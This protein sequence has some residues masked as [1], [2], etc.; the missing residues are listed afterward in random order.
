MPRARGTHVTAG[1]LAEALGGR[2]SGGSWTACCPGH[3]DR[4]PSLSISEAEDG[5][6]LV[7]CHAGCAQ[8]V[9]VGALATMGL[10]PTTTVGEL[11]TAKG[12]PVELLLESG[13]V[14][15]EWKDSPVIRMD[16]R[17]AD[18]AVICTRYRGGAGR[19]D[20]PRFW[21]KKGDKQQL[22]GLWRLNTTAPVIIVEGE[23][24]ALALW[25]ADFNAIGVPGCKAW[26]NKNDE[27]FAPLLKD[28]PIVY[29]HLEPD[30][31][32]QIHFRKAFERSVLRD[33]V[34]FFSCAPA[35]KDPCELRQ[36][37]PQAFRAAIDKLLEGGTP[38]PPKAKK[39]APVS[40]TAQT[41]GYADGRFEVRNDG[42]F[43]VTDGEDS[44]DKWLCSTVHITAQ[45]CDDHNN[46]WGRRL[47][48]VDGR[49]RPHCWSMPMALLEGDEAEVRQMLAA[50]GLRIA[51][52]RKAREY[53][54]A[55]LK[56]WPVDKHVRCVNRLGW[57]GEDYV[58]PDGVLGEQEEV[59][60]QSDSVLEPAFSARGTV[61]DWR[62]NVAA[63]AAG[64]TRLMF[65]ACVAFAAPL[66]ELVGAESGGF[67]LKG[68]SS[69]G[70]T[71]ALWLGAGIYGPPK[72]YVRSWR[73]TS[74]ALEST[75]ALHNDGL[76]VLDEVGQC[77]PRDIGQVVYMV[78]NEQGKARAY[79]TG[80]G[81]RVMSWRLL[82]L[83]SGEA[84]LDTQLST[85]KRRSSAGMEVRL[86]E[87]A[88]DAGKKQGVVEELHGQASS[89]ALIDALRRNCLCYH[90][91]VGHEWLRRLVAN[92]KK[93][94]AALPEMITQGA[95]ELLGTTQAEGQAQRVARRFALVAAA[96][97]LTAEL[98]GWSRWE[99]LKAA[100][101]CFDAWLQ[102][103]GGAK[104]REAR[105]LREQ[106][107]AVIEAHGASRFQP[108]DLLPEGDGIMR[109]GSEDRDDKKRESAARYARPVFNR[110]GF[111]RPDGNGGTEFLVLPEAFRSEVVSGYDPRWAAGVLRD[112]GWLSCTAPHLTCSVRIPALGDKTYRVYAI[113]AAVFNTP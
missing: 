29:V 108:H 53:L 64:N 71:S 78:A 54:A 40:T 35:A 37:D 69:S 38:I 73:T 59:V 56:V 26:S 110:M 111:T 106:V 12:L 105:L 63:L 1:E 51:P 31:G 82:M 90:G 55:Y 27:R 57:H 104:N 62:T 68:E 100:Q 103:F 25:A 41:C 2:E 21:F 16:Y 86:V 61:E 17:G 10:W 18:N 67:H 42:V 22:F 74:N 52:G 49:G 15:D 39:K 85:V 76:L 70:K 81:R 9:V 7:H 60:F 84:S 88:A 5:R 95:L 97:E 89:T 19:E 58:L 50:G 99:A 112:C 83:S 14:D 34:R 109:Q 94:A 3:N 80:D 107:R 75:A 102:A 6:I 45:T 23:T 4:T 43:H 96:G 47:E 8:E 30:D 93:I 33:K 36:R 87:I 66:L 65:V 79:R 113:T 72:A 98:T 77:D 11:S 24:D 48:W 32:G 20:E 92:R 91:A 101:A 44:V 46:A 13:F 28:C